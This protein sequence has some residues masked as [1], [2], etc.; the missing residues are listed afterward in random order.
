MPNTISPEK[1]A[2]IKTLAD[3]GIASHSVSAALGP[4][5]VLLAFKDGK[6]INELA[7]MHR[8]YNPSMG[9]IFPLY[10]EEMDGYSILG[11]MY[12]D[13]PLT[14]VAYY[15]NQIQNLDQP[16]IDWATYLAELRNAISDVAS[17]HYDYDGNTGL[18]N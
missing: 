17:Y 9:R 2:L 16:L 10:E 6:T 13:S 8:N 4:Q 12:E 3:E 14:D 1:L 5:A 7:A 18:I 15:W 11:G